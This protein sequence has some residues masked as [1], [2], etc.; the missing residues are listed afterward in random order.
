MIR[1]FTRNMTKRIKKPNK[2][3]YYKFIPA[4]TVINILKKTEAEQN[5]TLQFIPAR[6]V[7]PY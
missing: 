1:I 7:M 4:R 5:K 2:I 6:A 3:R